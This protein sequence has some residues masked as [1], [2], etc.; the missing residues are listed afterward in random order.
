MNFLIADDSTEVLG[1]L[2]GFLVKAGHSVQCVSDGE[3]ALQIFRQG[4]I[5]EFSVR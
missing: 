4:K 5:K 3:E 1:Y 2:R